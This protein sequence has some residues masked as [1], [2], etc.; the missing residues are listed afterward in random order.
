M[1]N[2]RILDCT[3]RDGGRVINCEFPDKEIQEMTG[4]L[5]EA[6]IDVVE[7]GFI[8]D[9]RV[10]DY[11]GNSTFFTDVEQIIPFLP[12]DR[13]NTIFTAFVDFGMYDIDSL[14]EYNELLSCEMFDGDE[15]WSEPFPCR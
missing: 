1:K 5:T 6:G 9:Q 13:K 7:I 14:K 11:R 3:L 4:R 15:L 8:R 2:V 10:I 12:N